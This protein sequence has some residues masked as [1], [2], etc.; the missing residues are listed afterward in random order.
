MSIPPI[1]LDTFNPLGTTHFSTNESI[2]SITNANKVT[3]IAALI[4]IGG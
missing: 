1:Y 3:T 2:K 4:I